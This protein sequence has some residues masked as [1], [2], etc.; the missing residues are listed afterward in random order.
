MQQCGPNPTRK[1]G[2]TRV[3]SA[4][5]RNSRHHRYRISSRVLESQHPRDQP[6]S[7]RR[8]PD[9]SY[10]AAA[11]PMLP[12]PTP[13]WSIGIGART[14]SQAGGDIY[15]RLD[16][17]GRRI[18]DPFVGLGIWDWVWTL[19]EDRR[20]QERINNSR[21]PIQPPR[22]FLPSSPLSVIIQYTT[23]CD[24]TVEAD[25]DASGG[26]AAAAKWPNAEDSLGLHGGA[27]IQ[28]T[29][30][31]RT[32]CYNVPRKKAKLKEALPKMTT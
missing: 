3:K 31:P 13:L 23:P 9:P 24:T 20:V 15:Y 11:I 21:S 19:E 4:A 7:S 30:H 10:A 18:W 2:R 17:T 28:P 22:R 27:I 16:W 14:D 12:D 1:N 29:A 5:V 32:R 26:E 8:N 25:G 6:S